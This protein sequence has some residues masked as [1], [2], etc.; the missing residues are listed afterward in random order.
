MYENMETFSEFPTQRQAMD[1][2]QYQRDTLMQEQL[3]QSP[4]LLEQQHLLSQ[5]PQQFNTVDNRQI[6]AKAY[7]PQQLNATPV[8][9]SMQSELNYQNGFIPEKENGHYMDHED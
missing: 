4:M 5:H 3:M 9:G 2:D 7:R 1:E 6:P 8:H